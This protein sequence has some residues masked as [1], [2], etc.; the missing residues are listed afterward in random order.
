MVTIAGQVHNPTSR[1]RSQSWFAVVCSLLVLLPAPPPQSLGAAGAAGSDST[2]P[3][4]GSVGTKIPKNTQPGEYE[5]FS[6]RP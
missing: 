1:R 6:S 5:F 3:T 4:V 2:S